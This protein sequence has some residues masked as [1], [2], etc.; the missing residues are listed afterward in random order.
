MKIVKL[1]GLQS[2]AA[3]DRGRLGL[4][5]AHV[6]AT[7]RR[8]AVTQT[9]VMIEGELQDEAPGTPIVMTSAI[10]RIIPMIIVA[11]EQCEDLRDTETIALITLIMTIITAVAAKDPRIETR[12]SPG[13]VTA[14]P[15]GTMK[16]IEGGSIAHVLI[17]KTLRTHERRTKVE[18]RRKIR[19]TRRNGGIQRT[20]TDQGTRVRHPP[21]PISPLR[22]SLWEKWER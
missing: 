18:G 8:S 12:G 10:T 9:R 13:D 20:R 3:L 22:A 16:A 2:D 7:G 11:V 19:K 14:I 5:R 1:H 17:Q 6:V 15:R 4:A 21:L